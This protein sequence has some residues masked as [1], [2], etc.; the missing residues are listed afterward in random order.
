MHVLNYI[1][2]L[3]FLQ[4]GRLEQRLGFYFDNFDMLSKGRDQQELGHYLMD[5]REM[6]KRNEDLI[7]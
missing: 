7:D 6:D 2:G 5:K 1:K 4:L 3:Y